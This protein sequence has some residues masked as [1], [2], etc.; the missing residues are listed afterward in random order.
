MCYVQV[1]K[2]CLEY[3][4]IIHPYGS[5]MSLHE[6][7]AL[8]VACQA[9]LESRITRRHASKHSSVRGTADSSLLRRLS[10]QGNQRCSSDLEFP[11]RL[12]PEKVALLV[13]TRSRVVDGAGSAKS[14]QRKLE[15]ERSI[16]CMKYFGSHQTYRAT[17]ELRKNPHPSDVFSKPPKLRYNALLPYTFYQAQK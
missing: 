4:I 6:Q 11:V 16:Q 10:K 13:Q 9:S 12:E 7:S 5:A 8:R 1:H 2:M 14:Y 17:P 3:N 15:R